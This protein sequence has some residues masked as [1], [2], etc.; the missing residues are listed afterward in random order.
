MFD[1]VGERHGKVIPGRLDVVC[2]Q[3]FNKFAALLE[4]LADCRLDVGRGD[5]VETGEAGKVEQ[6]IAGH[7]VFLLS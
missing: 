1:V 2:C 3:L 7:G 4:Q 5:C 6:G